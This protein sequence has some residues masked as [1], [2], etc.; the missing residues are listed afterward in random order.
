MTTLTELIEQLET[1]RKAHGGDLKV[2]TCMDYMPEINAW[3]LHSISFAIVYVPI[4]TEFGDAFP[5]IEKI[6]NVETAAPGSVIVLT[7]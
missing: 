7:P 6:E 5:M 2:M 4:D 3:P 1:L